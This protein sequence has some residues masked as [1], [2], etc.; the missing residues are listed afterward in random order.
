MPSAELPQHRGATRGT[1]AAPIRGLA[2]TE[3]RDSATHP[4]P[5]AVT[6]ARAQQPTVRPGVPRQAPAEP[7]SEDGVL[8]LPVATA[9]RGLAPGADPV[10]VRPKAALNVES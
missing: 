9:G 1:V 5:R 10:T 3:A 2:L 8:A 4:V 6:T 7:L